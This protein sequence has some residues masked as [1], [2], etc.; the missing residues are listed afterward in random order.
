MRAA[1]RTSASW[2]QWPQAP[3]TCSCARRIS[4][5]A[6]SAPST[7]FTRSSRPQISSTRFRSR[8]ASRHSS[9]SLKAGRVEERRAHR[10]HRGQRLRVAGRGVPLVDQLVRHQPLVEDQRA[11]ERGHLL[12]AGAGRRGEL[13]EPLDAFGR[14]RGEHVQGQAARAHQDQAPG[15]FGVAEREPDRGAPAE[16]VADQVHPLEPELVEQPDQRAG[17]EGEVVPLDR[18]LVGLAVAGLV[19][20]Q[21]AEPFGEYGQVLG[22][23]GGTRKRRARRRAAGRPAALRPLPCSAG[24]CGSPLRTSRPAAR[25][26]RTRRG[27]TWSAPVPGR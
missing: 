4:F 11:Q 15:A 1:C 8:C 17:R 25:R 22:E 19:D 3:N 20:D 2:A 27:R 7:G 21:G 23:V 18:R 6:T 16:G 24:A 9:P 12:P 14:V 26:G 10:R 5:S 13:G